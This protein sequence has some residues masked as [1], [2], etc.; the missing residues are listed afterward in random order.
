MYE[1]VSLLVLEDFMTLTAVPQP[2]ASWQGLQAHI[3][4]V[5]SEHH[6]SSPPA[7]DA[8]LV[9]KHHLSLQMAF[10]LQTSG[11]RDDTSAPR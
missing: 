8:L 3:L 9:R 2:W 10:W 4:P 11:E 6:L 7:Q 1:A 5:Q